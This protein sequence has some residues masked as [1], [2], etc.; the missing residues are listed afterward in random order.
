[1]GEARFVTNEVIDQ[2]PKHLFQYI[3]P[4]PYHEYTA[5]NQAAW[6]Y[7]MRQNVKHLS[8]Y[9]YG[10]YLDGL[11]KTGVCIEEIPEMYGMN[12][13][14]K[15]IGWAAVS[16]DG[17]IPPQAFMEFQKHKVLVIAADMRTIEH[18]KYT[19]APDIVHEAAGHA[20]IIADEEYA[21][22]LQLF[23]EIGTNAFSSALDHEIYEAIRHLSIIKENPNTAIEE[24][25][26]AEAVIEKLTSQEQS[27]SEM[28]RLRNL[29]WWTVEYGLI[30]TPDDF[31]I[32]GAGLLS[33]IGESVSCMDK[34]VEKLP[35]SIAAADMA[36]DITNRQPQLFVTPSFEYLNEVL[37]AFSAQMA[38]KKGGAYGLD[39]FGQSANL[40]TAEYDSGL[41]VSGVL[42]NYYEAEGQPF[43][44]QLTG[45]TALAYRG[46]QLSGHGKEYHAEGFGSPIGN[47]E[48]SEK[49]LYLHSASE[50]ADL[51][52]SEGKQVSLLFDS[53]VEVVGKV[54]SILFK[55]GLPIVISFDDCT[56]S[57]GEATLFLPEWGI[58]DM[59]V[60]SQIVSCFAGVA[61]AK[62]FGHHLIPPKEKTQKITY[63]EAQ[64]QLSELYGRVRSIR[65]KGKDFNQLI[66]V[67]KALE[68]SYNK[69]WLLPLEIL[70]IIEHHSLFPALKAEV[71][72]HLS[73]LKAIYP[74]LIQDGLDLIHKKFPLLFGEYS[75]PDEP[76]VG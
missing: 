19:P 69:E 32:Y 48:G 22:Y 55:A 64:L 16:V 33:S 51:G 10:S 60:G 52:I 63:S 39:A 68:E 56:V 4:Q 74:E 26:A 45:P 1:M 65:Q 29:H 42:T 31:K 50:L 7:I 38:W 49:P 20:P 71:I 23:G 2:L 44:M 53:G 76:V 8:Q 62:S 61:D 70:E 40:G 18:I 37:L 27:S 5:Q 14:L 13:I 54:K 35:Y 34:A 30:G 67:F 73:E 17:F 66:N 41:Q 72:A 58:Y 57:F 75:T 24:I 15:E 43:Y 46:E 25:N 28:A 21:D 11:K 3:I 6:R 47:L 36:F 59:A 12:R 9:A